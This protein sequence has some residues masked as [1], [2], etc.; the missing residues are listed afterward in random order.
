MES[1]AHGNLFEDVIIRSIASVGKKE[2]GK[3]IPRSYT[4]PMDIHEGVKSDF[5]ASVKTTKSNS[6][7]LGD[8][9][10]F[11]DHATTMDFIMILGCWEQETKTQKSFHTVYEFD[12]TPDNMLPLF[13]S[14]TRDD[15]RTFREYVVS[16]PPG[17]QGQLDNQTLWKEKRQVLLDKGN[18]IVSIDAKIDSKTQRRV[19]NSVKIYQLIDQGIPYRKI[20]DKYRGIELPMKI[21]SGARKFAKSKAS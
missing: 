12:C 5:N 18:P 17:K 21:K 2:Y 9:G 19:Q 8:M 10:V 14:L 20:T 1:Q 16:I 6:I 15:I 11:Y 3:L 4:S 7:G 13:G